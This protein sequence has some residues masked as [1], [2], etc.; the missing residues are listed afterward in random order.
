M[1]NSI[2]LRALALALVS[3]TMVRVSAEDAAAL[4]TT[5]AAPLYARIAS[6]VVGQHVGV[7]HNNSGKDVRVKFV[8]NDQ[9]DKKSEYQVLKAGA[10]LDL[11]DLVG[12]NAEGLLYVRGLKNEDDK[13]ESR[14]QPHILEWTEGQS[15][16]ITER[17]TTHNVFEN[18][19]AAASEKGMLKNNA[20]EAVRYKFVPVAGNPDKIDYSMLEAGAS[21]EIPFDG[22]VRI[23]TQARGTDRSPMIIT[24]DPAKNFVVAPQ[25]Q[26]FYATLFFDGDYVKSG[27]KK[28]AKKAARRKATP[29][30]KA[31]RK[32]EKQ[33]AKKAKRAERKAAKK[34]A[35][36]AQ[37]AAEK[38]AA[39]QGQDAAEK[40]DDSH[41]EQP[42][43]Q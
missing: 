40:H 17:R 30:R 42:A 19:S 36:Q 23:K 7:V 6:P 10:S 39:A 29:K 14:L 1:K 41:V 25:L 5:A 26:E 9:G 28:K 18:G 33:A 22:T 15:Y 2:M 27:V 3:V 8:F 31:S 13:V 43:A 34:A 12:D 24:I 38:N 37:R 35:R 32:V 11:P 4:T 21:V 16:S 20:G